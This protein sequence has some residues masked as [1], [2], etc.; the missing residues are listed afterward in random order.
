MATCSSSI[1][2]SLSIKTSFLSIDTTSPV[3]SSTKSST[4]DLRTLAASFLPLIFLR[5][6]LVTFTS[7]ARSKISKISLSLS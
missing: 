7:S 4:Q 1:I 6:A 2:V 3:S 5:F